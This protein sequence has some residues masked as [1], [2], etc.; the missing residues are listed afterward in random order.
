M[1]EYIR[2]E[3]T[4]HGVM[5]EFD[6]DDYDEIID[7]AK[8]GKPY[9]ICGVLAGERGE[10]EATV[11]KIYDCENV[12]ETP[13]TNYLIDPQEQFEI[14]EAIE[15]EGL[16]VVGFYHSHPEGPFRTSET[17]ADRA[18]WTGHSYV[19]VSLGDDEPKVG[20]WIWTGDEFEREEIEVDG[21][22]RETST[23]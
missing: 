5:I 15:D 19:I 6:V 12:S 20:S 2:R 3:A 8:D 13:E 23:D 14:V 11:E 22:S 4:Y 21:D 7:H 9:E 16:D 17:D 1:P 10:K 18:T